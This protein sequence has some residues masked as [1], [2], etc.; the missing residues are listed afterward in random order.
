MKDNK[1]IEELIESLSLTEKTQ[2]VIGT[3]MYMSFDL[4]PEQEQMMQ[5]FLED[6]GWTI[7]ISGHNDTSYVRMVERIRSWKEIPDAILYA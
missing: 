1:E 5:P 3:G 7:E 2:I 6:L 4:T